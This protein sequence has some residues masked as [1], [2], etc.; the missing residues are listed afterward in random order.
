MVGM[1]RPEMNYDE[2]NV[3]ESINLKMNII[4]GG[5]TSSDRA[6]LDTAK[7]LAQCPICSD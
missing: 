4:S 5:Q 6:A 3:N 1:K 2:I 7:I